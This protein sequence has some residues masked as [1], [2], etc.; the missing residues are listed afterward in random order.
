[1][2]VN[3]SHYYEGTCM[4]CGRKEQTKDSYPKIICKTCKKGDSYTAECSLPEQ[5]Q[6]FEYDEGE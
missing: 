4:K 1:M 2:G 3:Y 5:M 6:G